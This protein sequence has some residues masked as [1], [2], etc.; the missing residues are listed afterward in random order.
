MTNYIIHMLSKDAR[1]RIIE[2]LVREYG[3]SEVAELLGVSKPAVTKYI[4]HKTH[5]SDKTMER[6]LEVADE[7]MMIEILAIIGKEF[8]L[9]INDYN[10]LLKEVG[11]NRRLEVIL[12]EMREA[13]EKLEETI[14]EKTS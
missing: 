6:V 3:A 8:T 9:A 4:R 7:K 10:E 14:N 13:L 1:R 5:P 12:E 2:Y 11:G